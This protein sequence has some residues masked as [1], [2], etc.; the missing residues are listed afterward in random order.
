M[1]VAQSHSGDL[2]GQMALMGSPLRRDTATASV[3][4]ETLLIKRKEFLALV[5]SQPDFVSVLQGRLSTVLRQSNLMASQPEAARAV[6]FLMDQGLGE[7]TNALVI[8][9][10]LCI[11]CDNCERACAETHD[12]ISRL[13]RSAGASTAKLHVPISCRHC[14]LP[15]C[16]K[17]CPPDAIRRAPGGEVYIADTCIGCGNCETNCPYDAIKLSYPAP[18]KPSLFSWM[19]FGAGSGPGEAENVKPKDK[20]AIKKAVKCDA[21]LG[22]SGGPACVRACPTGAAVRL[23]P[24]EFGELV[25]SP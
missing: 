15:H 18:P 22:Q 7:A 20:N 2:V 14:E 10:S 11:G 6:G 1:V 17:D 3:R 4:T 23:G 16:M 12:G 9:E 5:G 13:N 19:F 24:D 25:R 8:N 21:C